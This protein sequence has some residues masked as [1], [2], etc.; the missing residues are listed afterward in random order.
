[1]FADKCDL[2]MVFTCYADVYLSTSIGYMLR[3]QYSSYLIHSKTRNARIFN[4]SLL[5][6]R[7]SPKTADVIFTQ[8]RIP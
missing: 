4:T 1:M 6:F 7:T 5:P 2:L 8:L 3:L